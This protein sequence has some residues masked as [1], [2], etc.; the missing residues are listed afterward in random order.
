MIKVSVIQ[1]YKKFMKICSFCEKLWR[2]VYKK[3]LSLSNLCLIWL[4]CRTA[5]NKW[6][7]NVLSLKFQP[8]DRRGVVV[9]P[10]YLMV[11]PR[12]LMSIFEVSHS[13]YLWD[14]WSVCWCNFR[15]LRCLFI[16]NMQLAHPNSLMYIHLSW[17][18]FYHLPSSAKNFEQLI[19]ETVWQLTVTWTA[20]DGWVSHAS[21]SLT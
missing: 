10:G 21:S 11:V 3:F 5:P 6:P 19:R 17:W 18:K 20:A 16:L 8:Q 9:V 4:S 2:C 1:F 7:E 12:Y 15:V 13:D 14:P